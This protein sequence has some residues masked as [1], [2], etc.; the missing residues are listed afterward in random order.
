MSYTAPTVVATGTT[1]AQFQ[2]GG[3]SGHLEL[4]IAA[5]R[6]AHRGP[7]GRRDALRVGLR[8]HAAGRDVLRRDHRVERIRRNDGRAGLGQPADHARARSRRH[9]PVAQERQHEPQHV[10]RDA[11]ST[12]PFTLAAS[13]HDR[14]VGHDLGAAAG[15]QL[16][17]EPADRQHDRA[18]LYRHQRQRAQQ[19]A[20]AAPLGA[21][22]AISR[23]STGTS[24][25]SSAIST[26]ASR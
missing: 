3:A 10:Y 4:L 18:D 6:L 17:R 21:R 12:G 16:R 20:R 2:A 11:S 22:T 19:A 7:D 26:A 25:R 13:G 9:V 24:G 23:W 14:S 1:F 5:Q 8:R 15:E